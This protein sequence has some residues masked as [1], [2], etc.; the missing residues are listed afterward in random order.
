MA[1]L[2]SIDAIVA[3]MLEDPAS[4]HLEA[5]EPEGAGYDDESKPDDGRDVLSSVLFQDTRGLKIAAK[6]RKSFQEAVCG[7]F[8]SLAESY[9]LDEDVE[10]QIRYRRDR[11]DIHIPVVKLD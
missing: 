7:A 1:P 8:A 6:D 11:I 5:N 4:S 2:E 10:P 9:F 3:K